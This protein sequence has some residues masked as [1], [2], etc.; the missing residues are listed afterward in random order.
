MSLRKEGTANSGVP[1]K[2]NLIAARSLGVG[3]KPSQSI[4]NRVKKSGRKIEQ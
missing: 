2:I 3:D 4:E 1:I